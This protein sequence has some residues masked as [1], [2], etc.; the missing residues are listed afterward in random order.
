MFTILFVIINVLQMNSMVRAADDGRGADARSTD[1][2]VGCFSGDSMV[3]LTNGQQKSIDMIRIGEQIQSIEQFKIVP[4]EMFFMLHRETSKQSIQSIE[5]LFFF[6]KFCCCS[7][8]SCIQRNFTNLQL[9]LVI[10]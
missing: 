2:H 4:S 3:M 10:R 1:V 8:S 5:F 6:F 9:N 7:S